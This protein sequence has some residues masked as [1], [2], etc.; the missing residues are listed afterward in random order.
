MAL[1]SIDSTFSEEFIFS[2]TISFPNNFLY[3]GKDLKTKTR[4]DSKINKRPNIN[5]NFNS[6]QK[7]GVLFR[8][9]CF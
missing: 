9:H 6:S 1:N 3:G 5:Q 4:K 7:T 2:N 8:L